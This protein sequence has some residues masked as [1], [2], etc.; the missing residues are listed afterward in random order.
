LSA[1]DW[2]FL[3]AEQK[4][5]S[6]RAKSRGRVSAEQ[7][8]TAEDKEEKRISRDYVDK[9]TQRKALV[10]ARSGQ[11]RYRSE[12]IK[13]EKRC[14]ITG[15]SDKSFLVA[16]HIKPWALSNDMEKLDS[17][18]GLLLTPN[19]D[20]AF[21]RGLISFSAKGKILISK[22]LSGPV[23]KVLG[24]NS[25]THIGALNLAQQKYLKFHREKVFK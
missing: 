25:T 1:S 16:S 18:N 11:G 2:K 10:N 20:R 13:R 4:R 8:I 7:R 9:P 19:L 23:S 22:R 14:R 15:I 3:L 12:L 24:I 17:N 21:D 6:K 5:V